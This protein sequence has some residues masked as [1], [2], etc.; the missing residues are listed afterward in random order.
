MLI[1]EIQREYWNL[2][3]SLLY[4]D[5]SELN[6][7]QLIDEWL[8]R[9]LRQKKP[10]EIKSYLYELLPLEA[11][12]I[13]AIDVVG[14][15][16]EFFSNIR[17]R[18]SRLTERFPDILNREELDSC[19]GALESKE[20]TAWCYLGQPWGCGGYDVLEMGN[21]ETD[22]RGALRAFLSKRERENLREGNGR[23]LS[24]LQ[25]ILDE[26]DR[27]TRSAVDTVHIPLIEQD[28]TGGDLKGFTPNGRL[29]TLRTSV[30]WISTEDD[31]I[32]ILLP[33]SNGNDRKKLEDE[34]RAAITVA[35]KSINECFK[36]TFPHPLSVT[37][38][39]SDQNLPTTGNSLGSGIAV[40]IA[41]V[42][43]Y[44]YS[45]KVYYVPN[46]ASVYTGGIRPDGMLQPVEDDQMRIK[47]R[48]VFHSP[49]KYFVF[50]KEN[51]HIVED[52]LQALQG[53]YPYRRLKTV[54]IRFLRDAFD[55]RQLMQRA[56]LTLRRRAGRRIEQ[57]RTFI[58]VSS[59]A[60]LVF[61]LLVYYALIHDWD[62][63]P[64]SIDIRNNYFIV[65]NRN[66]K[67]L[68][69]ELYSSMERPESEW[70]FKKQKTTNNLTIVYDLDGNGENEVLLGHP[71]E[72][73]GFTN[74][75]FC[76]NSDGSLRW[77]SRVGI[78]IKTPEGVYDDDG[79]F[80]INN[81]VLIPATNNGRPSILC[82]SANGSYTIVM[83]IFDITG[84][85]KT[86]Y[87]HLGSL[88]NP[89]IL[90]DKERNKMVIVVGGMLN[91]YRQNVLIVIDP[92]HANG[93]SIN[94]G[95]Y[96]LIEPSMEPA[97]EMY[98]LLFPKPDIQEHLLE[99]WNHYIDI[100]LQ[101]DSVMTVRTNHGVLPGQRKQY[102]NTAYLM[103]NINIPKYTIKD[104]FTSTEYDII[105]EKLRNVGK[106][107][108]TID[109]KYKKHLIDGVRYWNGSHFTSNTI[110]ERYAA[111]IKTP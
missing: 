32:N 51:E 2:K 20:W 107:H 79:G 4:L 56:V 104:V 12:L 3:E 73:D 74:Y 63:N 39:W 101:N 18:I 77:K 98:Y 64:A 16:P 69:R 7:L 31:R 23:E 87:V 70:T 100:Y 75:L 111:L 49:I 26:W 110:N 44:N 85:R 11:S 34:I 99:C 30:Q 89:V 43:L 54:P 97:A 40:S 38:H 37:V 88:N 60:L 102:E 41:A 24:L 27:R 29:A 36:R 81:I 48:T 55:H 25:D 109:E 78:S 57:Y 108:T 6:Q 103:W 5:G 65:M 94:R 96:R 106:I 50:A 8:K 47:T 53:K 13:P 93:V 62:D 22:E 58:A 1:G 90:K 67:E 76:Y 33:V 61:S 92:D 83:N 19:F 71:G 59:F 46:G 72:K 95:K 10:E 35:R 21:G 80:F 45:H 82:L 42:A 66:G 91:L 84:K 68:W 9:V 105:H 28:I 14:L 52:E 86:E 15:P 17:L